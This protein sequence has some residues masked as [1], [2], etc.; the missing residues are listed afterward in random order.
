MS[1]L[2]FSGL[3]GGLLKEG[4]KGGVS[5][6]L[7]YCYVAN[8]DVWR[9]YAII[10]HNYLE[11]TV[12]VILLFSNAKKFNDEACQIYSGDGGVFTRTTAIYEENARCYIAKSRAIF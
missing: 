11:T 8:G 9:G 4:K 7:L 2:A 1:L 6:G 10:S 5:I 3:L 12:A